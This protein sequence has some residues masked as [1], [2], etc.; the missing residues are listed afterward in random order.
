MVLIAVILLGVF[1]ATRPKEEKGA[2]VAQASMEVEESKDTDEIPVVP[3]EE[4][5]HPEVE[6]FIKTYYAALAEG[7][8]DTVLSLRSYTDDTERIKMLKKSNYVDKY[9]NIITYTK[10]GPIDNSYIAYVYYEVKFNE[11]DTLAP[12]LSSLYL[13]PDETKGFKIWAGDFD[14]YAA[15][16]IVEV[17]AQEDADTLF[18][19]VEVKYSEAI[20]AD[21]NLNKFLTELPT[22]LK[23]EVGEELAAVELANA[24]VEVE[25]EDDASDEA[26]EETPEVVTITEETVKAKIGRASCRERVLRLM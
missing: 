17:S 7:D 3:L 21:E 12:A 24:N 10:E 25:S 20:E 19:K 13:V 18:S 26:I 16:Y 15:K 9:E 23:T 14:E 22:R 2:E 8:M 1:G 4:G 11:I 5:T 6:E